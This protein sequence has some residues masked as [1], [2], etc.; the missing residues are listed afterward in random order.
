MFYVRLFD[1]EC[2][3]HLCT[4][5]VETGNF[6]ERNR[7]SRDEKEVT[8][9]CIQLIV[10]NGF[11]LILQEIEIFIFVAEV[12][13]KVMKCEYVGLQKVK[14]KIQETPV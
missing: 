7:K 9:F 6:R 12:Y 5:Q 2:C 14:P 1:F 13:Q 10:K 8:N 11:Q 4:V 3:C